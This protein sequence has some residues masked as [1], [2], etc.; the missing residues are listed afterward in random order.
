M[1]SRRSNEHRISFVLETEQLKA[2]RDWLEKVQEIFGRSGA[3]I[4]EARN[5]IQNA[6]D[7]TMVLKR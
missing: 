3:D 6:N 7:V 4:N 1:E 2:V 5:R